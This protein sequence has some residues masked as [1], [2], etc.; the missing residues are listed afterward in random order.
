MHNKKVIAVYLS[1]LIQGIALVAFPAISSIFTSKSGFNFSSLQY[2]SLF[3]PQAIIAVISSLLST[4]LIQKTSI[5]DVFLMG[6]FA[7]LLSMALLGLSYVVMKHNV[8]SYVL[9]SFAT[10]LL[11]LGFGFTVPCLNTFAGMF[12]PKKTEMATLILNA[13]LGL[14]TAIAPLFVILFVNLGFWWGLPLLLFICLIL[15][16]TANKK[17][18]LET[19][20]E[21]IHTPSIHLPKQFWMFALF[22]LIYGALETLNGNWITL[23]MIKTLK[24]PL[25]IA[26]LSL[27][28]FWGMVTVGRIF[29]ALI[30]KIL[31][32]KKVFQ[33][34]PFVM[35]LGLLFISLLSPKS[36]SLGVIASAVI[37]FGCSALLPLIICYSN[38][39]GTSTRTTLSGIII[40]FYLIG[41]GIGAFGVGALQSVM[42]LV[43]IFRLGIAVAIILGFLSY[44][45]IQKKKVR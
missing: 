5:K 24:E 10:A 34:L 1:G 21:H 3:I 23:H 37:G 19:N 13:L 15:L 45:I 11:G 41:Y 20:S 36:G 26:S 43:S 12:F 39:A 9:V 27:S 14:G 33:I 17:L 30:E 8:A 4:K 31:P 44:L 38:E 35:A 6:L 40:A 32:E 28:V 18:L 42:S 25:F 29:F 22:A 2:G 7:N 16:F